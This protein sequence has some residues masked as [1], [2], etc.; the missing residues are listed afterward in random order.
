M[1]VRPA[2]D[3]EAP[4][5]PDT[6]HTNYAIVWIDHRQ[7][8]VFHVNGTDEKKVVVN[9]HR[10]VQRLHH[11]NPGDGSAVHPADTEF[12]ARILSALEHPADVLVAGPG[13]AKFALGRY[14]REKRPDFAAHVDAADTVESPGEASVLVLARA[15]FPMTTS[16]DA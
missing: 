2:T 9:S 12:F 14:L 5:M 16:A 4:T 3:P 10:S 6:R 8:D 11:Q 7:A 15:H 13:Q 1:N